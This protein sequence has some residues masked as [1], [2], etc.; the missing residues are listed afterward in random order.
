MK[1]IFRKLQYATYALKH[2]FTAKRLLDLKRDPGN[3][4]LAFRLSKEKIPGILPS[5]I[6]AS[7]ALN[8]YVNRQFDDAFKFIRSERDYDCLM[9]EGWLSLFFGDNDRARKIFSALSNRRK[10]KAEALKNLAFFYY[11]D[12]QTEDAVKLLDI[13][14]SSFPSQLAPV[15]LL[16]RIVSN[17]GQIESIMESKN[18]NARSGFS[19]RSYAQF[20]RACNR[21]GAYST[22]E[23]IAVDAVI[24]ILTAYSQKGGNGSAG[25]QTGLP[26]G[27]F[28]SNKG[29]VILTQ[30][31]HVAEEHGARFF[32]MGGTLLG[33]VRDNNLLPWDKDLDFGCFVE[34]ATITDLWK[35]FCKS[36]FFLPM[37]TVEDRLIKLRHIT[38]VTVDI[39]VNHRDGDRRWHGGQFVT[40]SDPDFHLRSVE[41]GGN[42]FYMPEHAEAYLE[43]H[44]GPG[45]QKPDPA[46]DVFWEAPNIAGVDTKRRYVNTIAR[47]I[48]L[49]SMDSHAVLKK[50]ME[51]ARRGGAHDVVKGYS[52]VKS[53]FDEFNSGG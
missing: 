24:N 9:M 2:P 35:M 31:S 18:R 37:G 46:F 3:F 39:F 40:W 48:E 30:L 28:T 15:T 11:L 7:I 26:K 43:N 52:L 17:E 16:S 53:T 27:Q 5:G 14:I 8:L 13:A 1:N 49:I 42:T 23:D 6:R 33:M 41:F 12:G 34:E 21:A 51:R 25:T 32:L 47:A 20:I 38:G 50:R 19:P 10:H 44:Y 36:K 4:N 29:N 22:A 45:W